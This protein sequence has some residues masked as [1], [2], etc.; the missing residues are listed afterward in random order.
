MT[1]KRPTPL[2][3][4]PIVPLDELQD[5]LIKSIAATD[6]LNKAINGYTNTQ[7]VSPEKI[8][9][10]ARTAV[11]KLLEQRQ[12]KFEQEEQ[13]NKARGALSPQECYAKLSADYADMLQKCII[14]C[15]T[16][17]YIEEAARRQEARSRKLEARLDGLIAKQEIP[18]AGV[19]KT[20]FPPRPKRFKDV[21]AYLF[22]DIPLYSL[23]WIYHSRGVRQFL[24]I[25]LLFIWLIS[26]AVACRIIQTADTGRNSNTHIP[27]DIPRCCHPRCNL[28]LE[29][30]SLHSRGSS[31][32]SDHAGCYLCNHN[33]VSEMVV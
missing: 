18:A 16:Y 1:N 9:T 28:W 20:T 22:K 31:L 27:R 19:I 2:K 33:P 32:K 13:D 4:E 6:A 10:A 23:R 8:A 15:D 17:K 14:V 12:R 3:D 21:F 25:C 7:P 30:A 26:V 24:W 29:S 5:L 11:E